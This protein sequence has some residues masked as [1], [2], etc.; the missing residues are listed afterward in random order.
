MLRSIPN[1][2]RLAEARP[3]RDDREVA[4]RPLRLPSVDGRELFRRSGERA[5]TDGDEIV[6]QRDV[7]DLELSGDRASIDD[8]GQVRR[9]HALVDHGPRDPEGR[10]SEGDFAIA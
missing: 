3:G 10:C 8:P 5:E 1:E 7:R 4:P 2:A 6:E 9:L